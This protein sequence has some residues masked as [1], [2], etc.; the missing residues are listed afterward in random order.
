M[1]ELNMTNKKQRVI[2]DNA[3]FHKESGVLTLLISLGEYSLEGKTV[4]A[5]FDRSGLETEVLEVTEGVIRLPIYRGF[6]EAGVNYIQ[7]NIRSGETVEQ[8]PKMVWR[9]LPSVIAELSEG[10]VDII[11]GF[12]NKYEQFLD[13]EEERQ[14]AEATR[15]ANETARISAETSRA[16]NYA[17]YDYR[18]DLMMYQFDTVDDMRATTTL[19]SGDRVLTF[20]LNEI[21]DQETKV[22]KIVD[23]EE[24]IPFGIEE[25]Y[26]TANVKF[27]YLLAIFSGI[28][29]GGGEPAEPTVTVEM[30]SSQTFAVAT[31][32]EALISYS[33]NTTKGTGGTA[34]Y[35]VNDILKHVANIANGVVEF[36]IGAYL[37]AGQNYVEVVATD[38]FGGRGELN[39]TV[40]AISLSVTSIF[41]ANTIY[42]GDISLRYT[43]F[44]NVSK[45]MHFL[46]DGVEVGTSAV[47]A[48][49]AQQTYVIPAL[50]HGAHVI[51][52]YAAA[53]VEGFEVRSNTL[54]YSVIAIESGVTDVII[55][56][57]Y[58][59]A[60][61]SQG[62]T[63]TIPYR[64]YD[65]I[66]PSAAVSLKINGQTISSLVVDRGRKYWN[67]MTYPTGLVS[68][69]ITCG[70]ISKIHTVEV[71]EPTIN[72]TAVTE[73]LQLFLSAAGRSNAEINKD[74]WVYGSTSCLFN[75]FNWSSNGWVI[76]EDSETVLRLSGDARLTIPFNLF[77][78]DARANGFTLEVEFTTRDVE[79]IDAVL[80]SC[81]QGNIG[82]QITAQSIA[83]SSELRNII[84][85]NEIR[86]LFKDSEKVRISFVVEP[87]IQNK[88]IYMYINGIM[89]GINQYED[90]DNFTQPF[91]VGI[92][93][94]SS[95]A[96]LD[97]YTIRKYNAALTSH[98]I[99]QN[100]IADTY[101]IAEKVRIYTKNQIFD[102]YLNIDYNKV[103]NQLP[104]LTI[105]GPLPM[106]KGDKQKVS[107]KY[108]DRFDP[109]RNINQMDNVTID[110]QG[111]SSQYYPRK[112]Y[113]LKFPIS[114]KLR[115]DS[116]A[117]KVF[118]FKADF[119][120]SS[121]TH[122]TGNA[123]MINDFMKAV[124][125]IPPQ[126]INPKI[127]TTVDGVL[128]SIFHKATP[129][130]DPICFGVFNFNLDKDCFTTFGQ[131]GNV[132]CWELLDNSAPRCK[133]KTWD[134]VRAVSDDFEPRYV[135]DEDN[136]DY[137]NLE[138]VVRWVASTDGDPAK[139]KAE[140]SSYFNVPALLAYYV[141]GITLGMVDSFAKNLF[142]ETFDGNVWYPIFYDM[143]T[144][145]GVNNEG[146]LGFG[147]D[148]EF[149]DAIGTQ[150]AFNAHDS[151]LWNNVQ[152]A[153]Q[154]EIISMYNSLRSS[155]LTYEDIIAE[156]VDGRIA[157][158]PEAMYNYDGKFKYLDPYINDG[159]GTYLYMEQGSRE[160]HL[161]WWLKN[162]FFY[163][164]SKW[165]GPAYKD[166]YATMRLYTPTGDL[167]VPASGE[168]TLK[169][170][171]YQY[172]SIRF[173]AELVTYRAA[174]EEV[175]TMTPSTVG[176]ND[177]ETIIYGASRILDIGN[178]ANKYA[179]TIDVSK[180]IMLTQLIVGSAV[181]G[182]QNTNLIG[183]SVGNN[184]LLKRIN[185]MNCP[186]L[187]G[188]LNVSGCETIEEIYAK[189]TNLTSVTLP[190]GGYLK[191]LDL[192]STIVNL[193]ILN[194]PFI[195]MLDLAGYSHITA[196]RIENSP[197]IDVVNLL[198]NSTNLLRLRLIGAI[199][200]TFADP[201]L[202]YQAATL[203][204]IDDNGNN[205]ATSVIA[206]SANVTELT[207]E[208]LVELETMLPNLLIQFE[209]CWC[210]VTF[211]DWDDTVLGTDT[212]DVGDYATAP[213]EVPLKDDI[214][215]PEGD[216]K[217]TYVFSDWDSPLT[218]IVTTQN[219][220]A[221]YVE[222][223]H[224][225][226]RFLNWNGDVLDSQW[227]VS[228]EDAEDPL[229]RLVDPIATPT[230]P[231]VGT[232]VYA[233]SAW[234]GN[235]SV[236][237]EPTDILA[238][239][240]LLPG[241]TATFKNYDG[242][243]LDYQV[244]GFGLDAVD[245]VTR[246][247]DPIATPWK[248]LFTNL[249]TDYSY[250]FTGWDKPLT[251]LAVDTDFIAQYVEPEKG[252]ARFYNWDGTLLETQRVFY[253]NYVENPVTRL[254]NPIAEPT[255]PGAP[256]PGYV[257][258]FDSWD[259]SLL[260]M[261]VDT[262]YTAVFL[263]KWAMQWSEADFTFT[264]N[265]E[266]TLITAYNS[267]KTRVNVPQVLNGLPV[268]ID[269]GTFS[270]KPI[271]EKVEFEPGVQIHLNNMLNG[272]MNCERL[273][274]SPVIPANVTVMSS[275]FA[276]CSNLVNAPAIPNSVIDLQATFRNCSKL[277]D[278]P[279]LPH[280]VTN[281]DLLFYGCSNLI[282]APT[283]PV[284]VTNMAQA[285]FG[286]NIVNA[287]VIPS[288]VTSMVST[289]RNCSKLV[290]APVIPP[291]VTGLPFTFRGCTN[292]VNATVIPVNVT[293]MWSTFDNC[294][295]L[296]G[297]I[298][299]LSSR[300]NDG[301]TTF[302]ATTL[303]KNVY[304]PAVGFNATHNTYATALAQWHG[305][306][307]VT[308]IPV[309]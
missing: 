150:F 62:E 302:E 161:N 217:Y 306:N 36:D 241:V 304:V 140:V 305:K 11:T 209:T 38:R 86:T 207:Y 226:V 139:F 264:T 262:N 203:Q 7:L 34:K 116:I 291:N 189:G 42:E 225:L 220:Q 270:N 206:G 231:T 103:L 238:D 112:N 148:I 118:T 183:V 48:S 25:Y 65:P 299:I 111:T 197:T 191:I 28:G 155:G 254:V 251:A 105:T 164:D 167:S 216:I 274:S 10:D 248:T 27:A 6:P 156:L 29:G 277:V 126:T 40:N 175:V 135:P 94:G 51:E 81:L 23:T 243:V 137:T 89:S 263:E 246:E 307:G 85:G 129:A 176:F 288:N 188:A 20:G 2:I 286:T 194:Q 138:R 228:G 149:T 282:N 230:R 147:Y 60:E 303:P 166:D 184:K 35:Y 168:F 91:P 212:V 240:E 224:Y 33:F 290:N 192:P 61:T 125:P 199:G 8:S 49:G 82:L 50:S 267:S 210:T 67:V 14:A 21:G 235:Y 143:D 178:L 46:V 258:D 99:L 279:V 222:T 3:A 64:V 142:I 56:S 204:G 70:T 309:S 221:Q 77:A 196:I 71:S 289:F 198:T 58:L 234:I 287:P 76:N 54:R 22:Y 97:L 84:S 186:N 52:V 245:P 268:L 13:Y 271:L 113:K 15:S 114:Y 12:I 95:L 195:T 78:S 219:I 252:Y 275:A 247:V 72:V 301:T 59:L 32:A 202:L 17:Y 256:Q 4:T 284:N 296:T 173:G 157:H 98:Q 180:A 1:I 130:S 265:A 255:K 211:L 144:C 124:S 92:T 179:G 259:T 5:V 292:L 119:M 24:E 232:N 160:Q 83:F 169:S 239:F 223:T 141:I 200:G 193:T 133:F 134:D 30:I 218:E 66:S 75:G 106:V 127:R 174:K 131:S 213:L 107:I 300:V 257:Y 68:F 55:E 44:G 69:E 16:Q 171:V 109:N 297:D 151:V 214:I 45:T 250:T 145:Y 278:A 201:T 163:L 182:Y 47:I 294:T 295:N 215:V 249:G 153:Y 242:T 266:A 208:Q 158:I 57:D 280:N 285:F 162:R 237:T 128:C 298:V 115:E 253:G 90:V 185:V 73:D 79:N 261:L 63:L 181:E 152:N 121:H 26:L 39:Y 93:V 104:C 100:Y 283:I 293:N 190:N 260:Q 80:L 9:V 136:L 276:Y 273:V 96:T 281:I 205:I 53:T 177:T 187:G 227:I 170:S 233:Y 110:I 87:R 229:T 132:E 122:N 244:I 37:S 272:F 74:R 269:R 120:D 18:M 41:D 101:S 19:K 165:I 108:E 236:I 159:I 102:D 31:G 117:E 308:V 43:P 88:L 146:V 154:N 172:L 123:I